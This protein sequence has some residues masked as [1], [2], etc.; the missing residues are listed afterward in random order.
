MDY[1]MQGTSGR[2][3]VTRI[4]EH[5]VTNGMTVVR[6]WAFNDELHSSY[7][8]NE[9]SAIGLDFVISEV[10]HIP[11]HECSCLAA[12]SWPS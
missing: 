1:A 5:A 8:L 4:L 6:T 9:R 7:G 3:H 2:E 11:S 12:S 10:R